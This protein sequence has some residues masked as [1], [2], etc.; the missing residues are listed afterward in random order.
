MALSSGSTGSP[1]KG[2]S[3]ILRYPSDW[4]DW[5]FIVKRKAD[6]NDLW[7]YVDLTLDTQP[8]Q[9]EEPKYPEPTDL[10]PPVSDLNNLTAEQDRAF[11][12]LERTYK[13]KDK[14]YKEIRQKIQ[15]LDT[16]IISTVAKENLAFL[17]QDCDTTYLALKILRQQ[18]APTDRARE[19]EVANKYHTLRRTPKNQDIDK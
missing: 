19:I 4:D 9:P 3:V 14:K 7:Q 12:R 13:S 2:T 1:A 11:Q 17:R 5:L 8:Q 6:A 16:Y 18:F 10:V 15:D